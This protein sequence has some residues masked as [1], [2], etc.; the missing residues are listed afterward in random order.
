MSLGAVLLLGRRIGG[1]EVV[2]GDAGC[3]VQA[4]REYGR[5]GY[6]HLYLFN[7]ALLICKPG[8]NFMGKLMHKDQVRLPI[9][10]CESQSLLV[11]SAM[12]APEP[13]R[14]IGDDSTGNRRCSEEQLLCVAG[15]GR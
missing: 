15:N 6:R 7:D 1:G 3:G 9:T 11:R 10:L 12:I 14:Q 5:A 8:E 4:Y 13:S 2:V